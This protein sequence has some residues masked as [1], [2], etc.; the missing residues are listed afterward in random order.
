MPS[1]TTIRVARQS[2]VNSVPVPPSSEV[3]A[4]RNLHSQ[5][6]RHRH[7]GTGIYNLFTYMYMVGRLEV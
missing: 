5:T 3:I 1:E 7:T 6:H 4:L 2:A